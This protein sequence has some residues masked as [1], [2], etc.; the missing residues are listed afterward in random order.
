MKIKILFFGI[1]RDLANDNSLELEVDERSKVVDVLKELQK[2][3]PKMKNLHEFSTAVNEEYAESE[4]ELNA[5]D[6][7]AI[8][9]PVSGG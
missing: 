3:Y 1:A 4:T 8:I 2:Q 6:V 7:I 5:N 9:P